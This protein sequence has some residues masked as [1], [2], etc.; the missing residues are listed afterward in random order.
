MNQPTDPRVT[1]LCAVDESATIEFDP[2]MNW[3]EAM[4]AAR[5]ARLSQSLPQAGTAL[6]CQHVEGQTPLDGFVICKKCGDN[7]RP[8]W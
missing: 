7:L 1:A 3:D 5:K 4:E 8:A 2:S 6:A